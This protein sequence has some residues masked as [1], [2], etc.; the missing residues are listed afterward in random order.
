MAARDRCAEVRMEEGYMRVVIEYNNDDTRFSIQR[1]IAET[2]KE[3]ELFP[4]VIRRSISGDAGNFSVEFEISGGCQR[5]A[6]EFTEK[7]LRKLDL[8]A[9]DL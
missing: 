3:L 8:K 6:G 5:E 1:A 4:T 2:E 9:C 7:V